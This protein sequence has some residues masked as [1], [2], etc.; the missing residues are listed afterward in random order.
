MI[1]LELFKML[2]EY[3]F[4]PKKPKVETDILDEDLVKSIDKNKE[5][6]ED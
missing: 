3:I 1:L 5:N 4:P 6:S 2:I